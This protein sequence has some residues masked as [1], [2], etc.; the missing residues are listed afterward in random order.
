MC[1][2]G[3]NRDKS[4]KP[5]SGKKLGKPSGGGEGGRVKQVKGAETYKLAVRREISPRNVMYSTGTT[6]KDIVF[7]KVA[8]RVDLKNSHYKNK[9]LLVTMWADGP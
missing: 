5:A 7:W 8:K 2:C 4:Q 3:E 6:V 1:E 9:T